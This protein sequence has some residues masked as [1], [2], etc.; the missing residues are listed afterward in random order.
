MWRLKRA[1]GEEQR[2]N[3]ILNRQQHIPRNS[4]ILQDMMGYAFSLFYI[5]STSLIN[6]RF[7]PTQ[8]FQC[9]NYFVLFC[10][11]H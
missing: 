3:C 4:A 6:L 9:M 11:F 8:N 1:Q 5:V 7:L 10:S 2:G